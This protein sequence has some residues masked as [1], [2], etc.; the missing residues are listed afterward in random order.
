VSLQAFLIVLAFAEQRKKAGKNF[1]LAAEEPELHL[2]PS[3]HRRLANRIRNISGQSIVTTHSP[4][5]ASG[6]Q[7][8]NA[9]YARN[10]AGELACQAVES[11]SFAKLPNNLAKLYRQ[12][13]EQLYEALMGYGLLIPEGITDWRW[14]RNLQSVLEGSIERSED[15]PVF[16]IIP[17][18]DAA[19]VGTFSELRRFR[20]DMLPLVDGDS[21]GSEYVT[22]LAALGQ[23][24]AR[25]AQFGKGAGMECLIAYCLEP[26]LDAPGPAMKGIFP[27]MKDKSVKELRRTL[28]DKKKDIDLIER[29]SWEA[30][31]NIECIERIRVFFKD[32][33]LI[34]RG[35]VPQQ[36]KSETKK[37]SQLFIAQHITAE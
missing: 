34:L 26:L 18:Q 5:I 3:L 33:G 15:F 8:A 11:P 10:E 13:R 1:I 24:P 32:L 25:I 30:A 35:Q 21:P 7:T 37:H 14:I 2:H 6:F 20:S 29:L 31:E 9:L 22:Q 19:V 23:P 16:T 28:G 17:T 12:H 4:L 36:W 27:E